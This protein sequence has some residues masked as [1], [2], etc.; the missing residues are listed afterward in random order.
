MSEAGATVTP[1]IR[2]AQ[3]RRAIS[4]A[5]AA[6]VLLLAALLMSTAWMT[7]V[8]TV[9]GITVGVVAVATGLGRLPRRRA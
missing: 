1:V 5:A 9:L 2:T 7:A 3:D 4:L 6:S 8:L